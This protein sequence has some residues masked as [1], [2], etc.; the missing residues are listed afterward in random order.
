MRTIVRELT[1][2]RAQLTADGE[3]T[4]KRDRLDAQTQPK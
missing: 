1:F 4:R 3:V 2:L